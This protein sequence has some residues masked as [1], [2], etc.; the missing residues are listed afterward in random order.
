LT[1]LTR[2]FNVGRLAEVML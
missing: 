2:Y 1:T